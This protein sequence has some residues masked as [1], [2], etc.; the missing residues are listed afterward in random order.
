MQ[1]RW[2]RD[3]PPNTVRLVTALGAGGVA[4]LALSAWLGSPPSA[5][6][7]ARLGHATSRER[8]AASFGSAGTKTRAV[9]AAS[10]LGAGG[11]S[12]GVGLTQGGD[13]VTVYEQALSDALA[14]VLSHVAGAGQVTCWV[15]VA[16]TPKVV[17][18]ENGTTIRDAQSGS[19]SQTTQMS[20]QMALALAQGRMVPTTELAAPVTGVLVVASGAS[21][22]V[23][24]AELTQG[25]EALFGLMAN[26]VMVLP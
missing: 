23:V 3:L 11:G 4:L 21:D 22:P 19:G 17:L 2:L 8:A 18:A 16:R 6:V 14:R 24:R 15:T 26:Q 25:T 20:E 10:A 9:S 1:K 12:D 7:P 5:P 13:A